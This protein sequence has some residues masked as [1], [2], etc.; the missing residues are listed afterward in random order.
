[1]KKKIKELGVK[2]EVG[3]GVAGGGGGEQ[4][5]FYVGSKGNVVATVIS[6]FGFFFSVCV[7]WFTELD[8]SLSFPLERRRKEKKREEKRSERHA[9]LLMNRTHQ[10]IVSGDRLTVVLF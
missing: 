1:M 9:F 10:P 7:W 6:L 4:G 8:L 3:G 2:S 5:G